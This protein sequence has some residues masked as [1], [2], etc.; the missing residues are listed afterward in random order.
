MDSET[1]A[2]P[3]AWAHLGL[4]KS[5][6]HGKG[7]FCSTLPSPWGLGYH[8]RRAAGPSF[9][10]FGS[11]DG[12]SKLPSLLLYASTAFPLD[13]SLAPAHVQILSVACGVWV[14]EQTG[15]VDS[16]E[17]SV[18]ERQMGQ[19]NMCVARLQVSKFLRAE[20]ATDWMCDLLQCPG[21]VIAVCS[22]SASGPGTDDVIL[23]FGT[24][25]KCAAATDILVRDN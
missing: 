11:A 7:L 10:L 9:S 24:V 6:Q 16:L 23:R 4:V 18:M 20:V 3:F 21:H 8:C 15:H 17:S 13:G 22:E 5:L 1:T 19:A 25:C 14:V 12:A 2:H